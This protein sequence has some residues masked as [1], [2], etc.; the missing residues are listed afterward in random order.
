MANRN[1]NRNQGQQGQ[2]GGGGTPKLEVKGFHCSGTRE[3]TVIEYRLLQG[4]QERVGVPAEFYLGTSE[5][6][7]AYH[8]MVATPANTPWQIVT[9]AHGIGHGTLNVAPFGKEYTRLTII[10]PGTTTEPV[11]TDLPGE[12]TIPGK[13]VT[14]K[15]KRLIVEFP[16]EPLKSTSNTFYLPTIRTLSGDG[17]PEEAELLFRASELI[18]LVDN[19]TDL[20]LGKDKKVISAK[21]PTNGSLF[22]ECEFDG[23]DCALTVVHVESGEEASLTMEFEY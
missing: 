6:V 11:P 3:N 14:A 15:L 23:L 8:L 9:G 13:Q 5:Q 19:K 1:R 17:K 4:S 20:E 10:L 16:V 7:F 18:T 2:G 12:D 21:T 22:V